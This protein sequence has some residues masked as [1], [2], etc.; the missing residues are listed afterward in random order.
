M[1]RFRNLN[2]VIDEICNVLERYS[3][4]ISFSFADDDF[5]LRPKSELRELA[6]LINDRL[7]HVI[8]RS[9]W[10]AAATPSA[11]NLEKLDILVPVGLRAITIGVQTG[12]ERMNRE[13]YNRRF[14]NKLFREKAKIIDTHY[15]KQLIILL[16]FMVNCPY[17]TETDHVESVKLLMDLPKWFLANLYRFTFYP[18]SPI[19]ERAVNDNIITRDPKLYSGM[20]FW[21]FVYKGYP[22]MVHVLFLAASANYIL[23]DW[24]KKI[25]ISTPMRLFS[26]LI[27][28]ALLNLIPWN[29]LYPKIWAKNQN[30]ILRDREL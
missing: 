1:I 16:D 10:S 28:Q 6:Q 21:P 3:F 8:K 15:H 2:D 14:K 12:S 25:L 9:F 22:Y 4:F 27:P 19:Y 18:K 29:T 26:K 7:P 17:E 20:L 5:F 13:I 23:P 30:A 11:L 24:I